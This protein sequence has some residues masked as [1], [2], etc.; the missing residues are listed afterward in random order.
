[1]DISISLKQDV[2]EAYATFHG[3]K[4]EDGI[5]LEDFVTSKLLD[6]VQND[7]TEKANRDAI[8]GVVPVADVT[9]D[10]KQT[11]LKEAF[12]TAQ[13]AKQAKLDQPTKGAIDAT[14]IN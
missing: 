14:P 5:S 13:E 12:A 2:A 11:A 4:V 6:K 3:Y 7:V 10:L 8:A 1:M 9:S